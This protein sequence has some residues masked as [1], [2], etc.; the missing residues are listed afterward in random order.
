MS[1][2]AVFPGFSAEAAVYETATMYRT[3]T[4]PAARLPEAAMGV[5][6]RTGRGGRSCDPTC[7]CGTAEGCHCCQVVAPQQPEIREST[8]SRR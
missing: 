7:V 5:I 8:V 6:G 2:R 3:R 4:G 1:G